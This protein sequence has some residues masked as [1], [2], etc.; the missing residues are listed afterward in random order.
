LYAHDGADVKGGLRGLRFTRS[1]TQ[2]YW[3]QFRQLFTTKALLN[4]VQLLWTGNGNEHSQLLDAQ[5]KGS[6]T[7]NA[8]VI[9]RTFSDTNLG[10]Y[11]T[12]IGKGHTVP[13]SIDV[14]VNES[15]AD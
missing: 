14:V 12:P 9:G 11:I 7:D 2:N 5:L 1:A 4:G 15:S 6:S 8:L 10:L 3:V 13:E